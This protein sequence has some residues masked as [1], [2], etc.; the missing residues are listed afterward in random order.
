[1]DRTKTDGSGKGKNDGKIEPVIGYLI[2]QISI[3]ERIIYMSRV[4]NVGGKYANE[5]RNIHK[6]IT[7]TTSS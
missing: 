5:Q 1:M 7:D 2:R 4:N 3:K 6:E